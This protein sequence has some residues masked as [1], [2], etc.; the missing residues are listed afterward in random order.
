MI[1]EVMIKDK[2]KQEI[3]EEITTRTIY[4]YVSSDELDQCKNNKT[5]LYFKISKARQN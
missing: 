3:K 4:K 5:F 1:E 2:G